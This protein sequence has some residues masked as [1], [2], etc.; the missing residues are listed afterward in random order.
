MHLLQSLL[1]AK[2][3]VQ[4]V[5]SLMNGRS[6]VPAFGCLSPDPGAKC[7]TTGK[8]LVVARAQALERIAGH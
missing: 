1:S 7:A 8:T 2:S 5:T 4:G 6:V 3:E